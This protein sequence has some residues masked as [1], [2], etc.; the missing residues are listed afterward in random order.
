MP[1]YFGTPYAADEKARDVSAIAQYFDE[2]TGFLQMVPGINNGFDGHDLG[3]LLWSL[4]EVGNPKKTEVYKALVNGPT[5]GCW[6][7]YNERYSGD[8]T[9]NT[10]DLRSL[11]TGCN[12]SAIAK[13]WGLRF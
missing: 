3:Y 7:S 10:N 1:V 4:I 13:Y 12:L 5:V 6:G 8:G 9:R 11:E 2:K